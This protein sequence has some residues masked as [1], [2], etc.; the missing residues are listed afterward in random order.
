MAGRWL[1]QR[2]AA[3]ERANRAAAARGDW[4]KSKSGPRC[5]YPKE[6]IKVGPR[7]IHPK[8]QIPSGPRHLFPK[9][10]V[11]PEER[12]WARATRTR[13]CWVWSGPL[14]VSGAGTVEW[15]G[16]S[17]LAHRVAWRL[18]HPEPIPAGLCVLQRC[19]NRA[20]IK[21]A[22]LFLGPRTRPRGEAVGGSKLSKADVIAIRAQ[23]AAGVP[24][25]FLADAFGIHMCTVNRIC[26]GVTWRHVP[27]QGGRQ[28]R[29]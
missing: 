14:N 28:Q 24:Q 6:Q 15:A 3:R 10:R 2:V 18:T 20:C 8:E 1:F 4:D 7:C 12:F 29:P 13:G 16:E 23:E 26:T 19:R 9:Y 27:L 11:N 5:T 17:T 22:H 21:P 25:E